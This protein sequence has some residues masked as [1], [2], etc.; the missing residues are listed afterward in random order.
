M[1]TAYQ[2]QQSALPVLPNLILL[3]CVISS[4]IIPI[5]QMWKWHS[6]KFT[7]VITWQRSNNRSMI[8][9]PSSPLC[10]PG[11]YLYILGLLSY[12]SMSYCCLESQPLGIISAFCWQMMHR[13]PKLSIPTSF[14]SW[15]SLPYSKIYKKLLWRIKSKFLSL[16]LNNH[17]NLTQSISLF[18]LY[19][20]FCWFSFSCFLEEIFFLPTPPP[21]VRSFWAHVTIPS[22]PLMRGNSLLL[23]ISLS[24]LHQPCHPPWHMIVLCLSF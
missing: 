5:A 4:T 15:T 22:S 19:L 20:P 16:T 23:L 2:N 17:D 12:H 13:S 3:A 11:F 6:K 8:P 10:F 18:Q 7:V 21:A 1:L 24:P 9:K 14:Q